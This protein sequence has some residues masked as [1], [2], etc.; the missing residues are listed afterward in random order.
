MLIQ[1][2]RDDVSFALVMGSGKRDV[3]RLK[4]PTNKDRV[5]WVATL[6]RA[7]K[8]TLQAR[9]SSGAA[10]HARR[11]SARD[12][13]D[14]NDN[15]TSAYINYND[16]RASVYSTQSTGSGRSRRI[17]RAYSDYAP[18]V[19][20]PV[21]QYSGQ[22]QAFSPVGAPPTLPPRPPSSGDMLDPVYDDAHS[23]AGT[24]GHNLYNHEF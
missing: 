22:Q 19:Q 20:S 23:Y 4:A 3:I 13:G 5:E 11:P 21:A 2:G 6:S 14:Y 8:E 1:Q 9:E 18:S 24:R 7:R 10:S 17:S 16:N 12:S 15:R